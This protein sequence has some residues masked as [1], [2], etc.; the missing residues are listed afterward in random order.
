MRNVFFSAGNAGA[1]YFAAI[2]LYGAETHVTSDDAKM[3]SNEVA[4]FITKKN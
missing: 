3:V 4:R 1:N 2:S